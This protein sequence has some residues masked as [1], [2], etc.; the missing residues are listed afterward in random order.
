MVGTRKETGKPA[1]LA[2]GGMTRKDFLRLGGTGLA[3]V[4]FL[5]SAG[6]GVFQGGQQGGGGAGGHKSIAFNLDDTIRDL[7]S[8][9]TTDSV[10]SDVLLNVM[11]GLYRLDANTRPVP[12]MAKSVEISSDRLTYTFKLRDGHKMVERR[13]CYGPGL[14][15]R[16]A[17]G[18]RPQDRR[19]VRLH[20]IFVRR[21]RSR[22][23]RGQ[24]RRG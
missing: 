13:P 4:A 16:L 14:Q 10:S 17:Q 21:G 22:F 24:G 23:Q 11:S 5:G 12:D 18:S 15:V 8:T 20:H 2:P 1:A 7:D 3:G 9:T 19:P 6:C